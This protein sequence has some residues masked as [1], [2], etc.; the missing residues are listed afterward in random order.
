[1]ITSLFLLQL[2]LL[3]F[4]AVAGFLC[5]RSEEQANW[6]VHL[7]AV[8]AG[9]VGVIYSLTALTGGRS[10]D[11]GFFSISPVGPLRLAIDPLSA[12]FVLVI[13]FLS[14]VT[15][16][17]AIGY[18]R[19]YQGDGRDSR[20]ACL[21][22][23]YN[24]FILSMI[25]VVTARDAFY[26]L[27]FWE[28]MSLVSYFLVVFE[29]TK[30]EA[31]QAGI[32]YFV[33]T[34][35][36]TALIAAAFWLLFIE[37]GSFSFD[38]FRLHANNL[39]SVVK[40][41]V[42]LCALAGFGTKAGLVPVHVW[43]P[44]AHPQAPS[45]V[46]ALMSGVMI[47]TAVYAL[48]RFLFTFLGEIPLWWGTLLLT[49]AILS[50]LFGI[51]YALM[52][53]DLKRLLAFSSIENMGI[54]FLGVG[55]AA[56]FT[57][58]GEPLYAGFALIAALYHLMN[59]AFFKGLLFLGAGSVLSQTHTRNMEQLGGLIRKMPWTAGAFLIGCLAISALP[60]MNGFVSEWMTLMA[61][62][63]GSG[64]DGEGLRFFTP[65]L[66]SL[67]G[68]AGALAATCFVK[69]F[70][71]TFLGSPRSSH[72][73]QATEASV[74]MKV[75]L[76]ILSAGCVALG[77]SC[78]WMIP[79]LNRAANSAL[80]Y[81]DENLFSFSRQGFLVSPAGMSQISPLVI[82]FTLAVL[83]IALVVLLGKGVYRI[84][85]SWAC[86]MPALSPRMQ[87]SAIGYSKPMRRV[88]SFLYRPTRRVEVEEEGHDLLRTAQ[89]FEVKI[90]P[91]F[92]KILYRPAVQ[93]ISRL[94][95]RAK[96]IQR[97]H[98][99]LYLSYIFIT[100]LLLLI[101]VRMS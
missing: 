58:L 14:T 17:Y 64:F 73:E 38:A 31:R 43:L 69:A 99:Q 19:H 55:M 45:H 51:L 21:G 98:I 29:H 32:F 67:L 94:S 91:F 39:P 72:S 34:H 66:A 44:R 59:H 96:Q 100:L 92:E 8:F 76:G 15:S 47:K 10:F 12:F 57:S 30:P 83:L 22:F 86:G 2:A 93:W 18:S 90:E 25:L 65:V 80:G 33:M 74:S 82:F 60:P 68:F 13:S 84:G 48:I 56:V 11:L 3:V 71:I 40:N 1:M 61:L 27:I 70:G 23:L 81:S 50:T 37:T 5:R 88:F 7:S 97:G 46:S 95:E 79:L 24:L 75:G 49:V 4:G 62:L 77:I 101:F 54:I 52:E 63:A 36:G 87:Y 89:R 16:I 42:F 78:G 28:V 35:A 85:P 53:H 26:F 9:A 41:A 20:I 6:A